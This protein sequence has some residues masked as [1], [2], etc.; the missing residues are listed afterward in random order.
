MP[1]SPITFVLFTYN[2]EKR[3]AWAIQNFL[4]FGRIL[5]VDNFSTDRT[6]E[7]AKSF[8]CDVLL[9]KNQGWVEDEVTTAKVKAAVQTDWIYW[10]S[11]DE[12]IDGP[13]MQKILHAIRS[14]QYNIVNIARK[15]YYY[16]VFCHNAFVD[17]MNRIFKKD[18]I[19][20]T[21][22][23][24]H[25]FG[26]ATVPKKTICFLDSDKYYVHHFIS[27]TSKSYLH[28]MDR[29]TDTEPGMP[30]ESFPKTKLCLRM[31]KSFLLNYCLGGAYK[32]G[33]PG[34]FLVL[35]RMYYGA[36][37]RMKQYER[38]HGLSVETILVHND[39][40]RTA[41]LESCRAAASDAH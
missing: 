18:A 32:A 36:L 25:N 38:K 34:L 5:V 39:P 1:D 33:F 15:N 28:V 8:G 10:A 21:G 19:D 30:T 29:Y 9:N 7:I 13:S 4:P 22:N 3:V 6:V 16:G 37:T 2:E 40:E 26:K 14:G 23:T 41:L 35:N 31:A 12:M 20:F 27:N 17:R 24:I 11:A